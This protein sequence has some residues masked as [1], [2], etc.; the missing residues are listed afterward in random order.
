MISWDDCFLEMLET[1]KKRSPDTQTQVACIFTKNNRIVSSGYNGFPSGLDGLPTERP[2]KYP[3]MIHSE[4][5][6]IVNSQDKA[7]TAYITHLPCNTCAKA[8]WQFGIRK[9]I[10]PA[11]RKVFSFT[12]DDY[13][14]LCKLVHEGMQLIVGGITIYGYINMD[15]SPNIDLFKEQLA[16]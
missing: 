4:I 10:I 7:E 8:M 14:V 3:W 11:N 13:E 15:Y 2:A 12:D 9:C 6:A 16:N 1:V 5:N